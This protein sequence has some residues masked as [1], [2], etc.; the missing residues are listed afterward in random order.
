[1]P[2]KTICAW[3]ASAD[4][5]YAADSGAIPLL[6]AGFHPTIVGDLDSLPALPPNHPYS[7]VL[8]ED[9]NHSDCDKLLSLIAA[10]GHPQ[11]TLAAVEGDRLDHMLGTLSSILRSPLQIRLALRRGLGFIVRPGSPLVVPASPNQR[12]SVLP[13]LPSQAVTIE[14][15]EWP[16]APSPMALDQFISLSNRASAPQLRVSLEAGAALLILEYRP[17]QLPLW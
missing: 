3:A 10:D 15:A 17:D 14:G 9:Q 13:L 11:A 16:V 8:D 12:F 7:I 1:M 4:R 6:S 2:A 5:L